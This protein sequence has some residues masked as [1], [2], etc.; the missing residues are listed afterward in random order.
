M[1]KGPRNAP[2]REAADA[3]LSRGRMD[4]STPGVASTGGQEEVCARDLT[5]LCILDPVLLILEIST[6]EIIHDEVRNCRCF[7]HCVGLL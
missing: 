1:T 3:R 6:K 2:T 5:D 7:F 4:T